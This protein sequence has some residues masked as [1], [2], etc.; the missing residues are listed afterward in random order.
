LTDI[1]GHIAQHDP[2]AALR[3]GDELLDVAEALPRFPLAGSKQW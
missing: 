1:T 2:A 3:L